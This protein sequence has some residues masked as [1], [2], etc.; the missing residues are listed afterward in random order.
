[1]GIPVSQRHQANK[2]VSL[3]GINSQPNEKEKKQKPTKEQ[4][5]KAENDF[6]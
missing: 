4:K 2:K 1:M 3:I 6:K 5:E